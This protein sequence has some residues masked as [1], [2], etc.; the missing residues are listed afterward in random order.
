MHYHPYFSG[1]NPARFTHANGY[2]GLPGYS[3]LQIKLFNSLVKLNNMLRYDHNGYPTT[4]D[5]DNWVNKLRPNNNWLRFELNEELIGFGF[6]KKIFFFTAGFNIHADAGLK[7]NKDFFGF[8]VKG[9]M[10]YLGDQTAELKAMLNANAYAELSLGI[11]AQVNK[12]IYIGARPRLL[13]GLAQV[14]TKHLE[15]SIHTNPETYD[16]TLKYLADAEMRSILP[17]SAENSTLQFGQF[18][19]ADMLGKM[20]KNMG[21]AIDLG[22]VYRISQRFGAELSVHDLGFIRWRTDGLRFQST[23]QNS[24]NFYENGSFKLNGLT[25]DMLKAILNN[26]EEPLN[27]FID[28]LNSYFPHSFE[29]TG[30][31]WTTLLNTRIHLGGYFDLT[32]K[33]RFMVQ[34]QGLIIGKSFLP[35][36]T[37]AYSG[38]I[39]NFLD[40]SVPYTVMPGS[41][42]NLGLGIGFNIYGLYLYAATQ[43]ILFVRRGL[44]SQLN[45]QLGIV[46]NW[47]Y[48]KAQ[49]QALKP[50]R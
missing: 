9:N 16:V 29:Q 14:R 30:G 44:G 7:T 2:V 11:Q 20:G 42:D 39:A 5:L 43:N 35:A 4:I 10:N 26:D 34:M 6:R 45:L 48:K 31:S 19:V 46:V 12:R 23:V 50:D 13:F 15:A 27:N 8:F 3:N 17:L 47:G 24:G 21:F 1:D 32:P 22:A 40:I 41:Y 28:S 33:H 18:N 38:R 25:S 49:E 36:V 37:I